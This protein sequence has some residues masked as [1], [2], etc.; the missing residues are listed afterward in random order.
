MLIR[1]VFNAKVSLL[2]RQRSG[3]LFD[4]RSTTSK[5]SIPQLAPEELGH[6]FHSAEASH[7]FK[8]NKKIE[9]QFF[10]LLLCVS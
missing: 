2:R 4:N 7:P 6:I 5:F 1:G 10:G 3:R 8:N 9:A